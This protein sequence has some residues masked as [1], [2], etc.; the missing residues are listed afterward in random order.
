MTEAKNMLSLATALPVDEEDKAR[1]H[2][3]DCALQ[4]FSDFG[5][6]RTTMDDVAAKAGIGRAT[7]YRRFRDKD[8]LFQAVIFREVRNYLSIIEQRIKH[9]ESPL[10]GLLEA[11]VIAVHLGHKH[12]LLA[13]LLTSE[14][15]NVLPHLT[16]G[17]SK[18]MA[19]STFYLATQIKKAQKTKTLSQLPVNTTAEMLLRLVQSLILSPCGEI[20]PNSEDSLRD[21]AN[22]YLRLMLQP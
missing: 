1:V 8:L 10:E 14:P 2:I 20:D 15:D 3:L 21:F 11:F 6:R 18:T 7:L 17:L 22:R 9:I 5:L 13:R 4:L 19:F 12:P 16:F